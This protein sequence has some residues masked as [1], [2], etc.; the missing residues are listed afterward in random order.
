MSYPILE[1][2][3]TRE[4]FI[5]PSKV[6][7]PRDIPEKIV[8]CFFQEVIKKVVKEHKA[9][10]LVRNQ[11]EDGPHPLYE[12]EHKGQRLGFFHPGIG[13]PT[14]GGLL[15]EVI[16]FGGRKFIA[17][18]GAGVLQPDIAVGNLV[19]VSA[20]VRDEGTSY[21]YLPPGREV[22]AQEDVIRAC[23]K[24]LQVR[25]I[26]YR[27]GKTWTTDAPYRETRKKIVQR[28]EEGCLT[29]EMEAAGMM[30]V[31]QFRNVAFGQILYGGDTLSGDE[32]DNRRWQSRDHIRENLFW[33]CAD[34]CLSL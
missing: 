34:L 12:I 17:C 20:A 32:W 4:A 11:W 31:A 18:G 5:E 9:K 7:E 33:L 22:A 28:K 6:N 14:A 8:I 26:P 13:G 16:A 23:E 29:V 15:E 24:E 10:M 2:D 27:L 1:F 30:A 21:H 25:K 19:L 3:E